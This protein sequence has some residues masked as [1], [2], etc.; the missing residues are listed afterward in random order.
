MG[1]LPP[2][3]VLQQVCVHGV[4]GELD[5]AHDGPPHKAVLHRQLHTPQ[6]ASVGPRQE[7]GYHVR[8]AL[9][10]LDTDV[11]Q[12]DVEELVDGLQAA[13]D[14]HVVLQLDD[15]LLANEGL[16]KGVEQLE[17]SGVCPVEGPQSTMPVR[18]VDPLLSG[19]WSKCIVTPTCLW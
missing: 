2:R 18:R 3:R 15:N 5:V 19:L 9:L 4:G 7:T 16:E 6:A 11:G 13:T 8:V 14:A 10:V 17:R 12:L 1:G